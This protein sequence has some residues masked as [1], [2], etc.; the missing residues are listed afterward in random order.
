MNV[1]VCLIKVVKVQ[2]KIIPPRFSSFYQKYKWHK[3][4]KPVTKKRPLP[5]TILLRNICAG[6]KDMVQLKTQFAQVY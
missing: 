4:I 6:N 2:H 1:N 3:T 5:I